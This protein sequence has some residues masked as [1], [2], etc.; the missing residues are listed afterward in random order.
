MDEESLAYLDVSGVEDRSVEADLEKERTG[1]GIQIG[2]R[3]M[4]LV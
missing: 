2:H 3:D 1:N 4:S